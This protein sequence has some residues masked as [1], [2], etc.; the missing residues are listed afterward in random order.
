MPSFQQKGRIRLVYKQ[1]IVHPHSML[2]SLMPSS[3]ETHLELNPETPQVGESTAQKYQFDSI[4]T[5]IAAIQQGTFVIAV[6][7][8]D[9]EN[10]GDLII[11]AEHMTKEK[12]AFMIRYT[13]YIQS[14]FVM[15][16]RFGLMMNL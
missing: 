8:E 14:L 1:A 5:A 13:R 12:A 7:N 10:E 3:T 9:R 11:A 2:T 6:D 16:A 4:E 15:Q